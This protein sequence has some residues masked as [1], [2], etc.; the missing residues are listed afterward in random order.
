MVVNVLGTEYTIT[1][2]TENEDEN[3]Q[4]VDGYC[5]TSIKAIV[6]D[7][8]ENVHG[9]GTKKNLADYKKS[10]LRHE[11]VHAYL[12]ESGLAECSWANNE[13]LVDWIAIQVTKMVKT[14]GE[15]EAI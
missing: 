5:D 11:L 2:S 7:K 6:I 9:P 8:M 15:V 4:G 12:Y 3:L 1:E 14:F 13:A 10:V